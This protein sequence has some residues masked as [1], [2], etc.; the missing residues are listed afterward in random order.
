MLKTLSALI[1]QGSVKYFRRSKFDY[2]YQVAIEAYSVSLS[3][4]E[5]H[6][7]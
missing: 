2:H 6:C 5:D 3:S 4:I 7:S 1:N